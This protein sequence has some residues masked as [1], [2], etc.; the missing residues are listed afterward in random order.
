MGGNAPI[1]IIRIGPPMPV[2]NHK[3]AKG[4]HA[5]G[6]T[7]R[8][9]SKNGVMMRS[10]HFDS[11]INKPSGMPIATANKKPYKNQNTNYIQTI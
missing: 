4:I 3:A 5:I 1:K 10:A 2:P 6:A 7:K 11:A 8:M 9:L